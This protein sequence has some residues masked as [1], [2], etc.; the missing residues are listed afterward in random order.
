[1][2]SSI[3]TSLGKHNDVP[4]TNF[5]A[6]QL[7]IGIRIETEHT[8]D[9]E[10]AKDIAKDHLAEDPDYYKKLLKFVESRKARLQESILAGIK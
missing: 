6:E 7:A 9:V 1:M 10:I 2:G 4:D 5:D 8:D 3:S